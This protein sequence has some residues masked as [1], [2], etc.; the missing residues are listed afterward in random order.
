MRTLSTCD[1]YISVKL[2]V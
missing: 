2:F 1:K